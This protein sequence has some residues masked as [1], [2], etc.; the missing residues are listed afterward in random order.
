MRFSFFKQGKA[1]DAAALSEKNGHYGP[2]RKFGRSYHGFLSRR[3]TASHRCIFPGPRALPLGPAANTAEPPILLYQKSDRNKKAGHTPCG[4]P[5][6]KQTKTSYGG[7]THIRSKGRRPNLPLSHLQHC[8]HGSP[9]SFLAF[10]GC[11]AATCTRAKKHFRLSLP[12]HG[13]K[14]LSNFSIHP[15]KQFARDL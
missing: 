2:K 6:V 13:G 8:R 3:N 10:A 15:M 14:A 11:A 4:R 7:I 12:Q 1:A 9:V 5:C